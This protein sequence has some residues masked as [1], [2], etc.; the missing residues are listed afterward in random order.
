M[1]RPP[2]PAEPACQGAFDSEQQEHACSWLLSAHSPQASPRAQR[3]PAQA[4]P[5]ALEQ[6]GSERETTVPKL[7][8]HAWAARG[9]SQRLTFLLELFPSKLPQAPLCQAPSLFQ[10]PELTSSLRVPPG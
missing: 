9:Y 8:P 7:P 2:V 5:G 10:N 3:A 6:T 1:A 4:S